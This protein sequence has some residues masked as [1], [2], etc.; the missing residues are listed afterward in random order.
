[1]QRR[2][3]AAAVLAAVP[4]LAIGCGGSGGSST[5]ST[6]AAPRAASTACPE[7]PGAVTQSITLR[8]TTGLP[9]TLKTGPAGADG[10][11]RCDGSPGSFSG[12]GNPQQMNGAI[13]PA[14]GTP[15]S[16]T[17]AGGA[18]KRAI[19]DLGFTVGGTTTGQAPP[20]FR[21]EFGATDGSG[22]LRGYNDDQG[23]GQWIEGV[24][25]GFKTADGIFGQVT[26][27]GT[28]I[29]FICSSAVSGQACPVR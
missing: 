28:T 16:F 21:V 19:F 1:M 17:L 24:I 5:A 22:R 2:L 27:D 23:R 25:D 4:V 29:S 7:I 14:D 6:D 10:G 3:G 26:V 12:E 13:L 15:V 11:Y 9:V 8:S 20:T 18:D